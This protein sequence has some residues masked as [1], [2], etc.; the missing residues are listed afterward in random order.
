MVSSSHR[1][2]YHYT[3]LLFTLKIKNLVNIFFTFLLLSPSKSSLCRRLFKIRQSQQT[4][5]GDFL[6]LA[7]V[8]GLQHIY[9]LKL[10]IPKLKPVINFGWLC[11]I[12]QNEWQSLRR[13]YPRISHWSKLSINYDGYEALQQLVYSKLQKSWNK[14]SNLLQTMHGI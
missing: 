1:Q 14:K 12:V 10:E 9:L 5:L 7:A 13:L 3:Q 6:K 8:Q 4:Y 11:L 2:F